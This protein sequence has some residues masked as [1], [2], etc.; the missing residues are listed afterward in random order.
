[1]RHL[2]DVREP[3][4]PSGY[5]G[6]FVQRLAQ[7][8]PS[9]CDCRR[10]LYVEATTPGMVVDAVAYVMH[11]EAKL[12]E[13]DLGLSSR[14]G[15]PIRVMMRRTAG[16]AF[17]GRWTFRRSRMHIPRLVRSVR[18]RLLRHLRRCDPKSLAGLL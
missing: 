3:L 7:C 8:R 16:T 17:S 12:L 9:S 14:E 10:A 1:M 11:V 2:T 18:A 6:C 5:A 4:G 13:G 15:R